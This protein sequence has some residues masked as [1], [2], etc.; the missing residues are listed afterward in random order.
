MINVLALASS[1]DAVDGRLLGW[2]LYA[3]LPGSVG[4]LLSLYA[5]ISGR[6]VWLGLLG[7]QVWLLLGSLA[8]LGH[9]GA[10]TGG[11]PQLVLTVVVM[12]LLCR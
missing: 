6:G 12:V 5:R 10:G 9:A 3:A 4:F 7:V 11:L 1:V 8:T 2:L